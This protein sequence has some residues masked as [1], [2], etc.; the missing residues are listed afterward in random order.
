MT[1]N[2]TTSPGNT[3]LITCRARGIPIPMISWSKDGNDILTGGDVVIGKNGTLFLKNV[4]EDQS[5]RYTC[6]AKSKIGRDTESSHVAVV[7]K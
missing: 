2:I 7:G 3:I 4:N 6:T 1:D 5:G